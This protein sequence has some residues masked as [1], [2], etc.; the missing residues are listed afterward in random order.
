VWSPDGTRIAYITVGLTNGPDIYII[1]ATGG[2]P[3]PLQLTLDTKEEYVD[4]R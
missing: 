2:V 4:W 1:N 3:I